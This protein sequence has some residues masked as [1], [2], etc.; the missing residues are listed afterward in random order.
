VTVTKPTIVEA[1]TAVK[2]E[3]GAV[4]KGERNSQQGFMF[5]GIDAVLNAVSPALVRYGVVVTPVGCASEFGT[6]EVGAKRTPMGHCKVLVTYRFHGPGGDHLDVV[7]PGEAMDSGDKATAKAMSVAYRIALLQALS[8]PTDD[9]DP[10]SHSYERSAPQQA[11]PTDWAWASE[12]ERRVTASA[13]QQ[14]LT[15]RWNELV[16]AFK[17]GRINESDANTL[18][19]VLTIRKNELEGAPA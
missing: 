14:D 8:L 7:V 9:P 18:K 13:S 17:D 12:F 5:R 19:T 3:V 2:A 16:A 1:L 6:V 4:G 11:T 15:D 10:D